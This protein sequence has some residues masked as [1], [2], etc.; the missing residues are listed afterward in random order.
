MN[1]ITD[2]PT[3]QLDQLDQPH[4]DLPFMYYHIVAVA[5]SVAGIPGF[6]K[7]ISV[8][9]FQ[10][11]LVAEPLD[12]RDA[13]QWWGKAKESAASELRLYQFS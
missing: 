6:S 2:T 11:M 9:M 12:S 1:Q 13:D 3:L 8:L 4:T 5:A 10:A 7:K